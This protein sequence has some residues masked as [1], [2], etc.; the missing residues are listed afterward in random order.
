MRVWNRQQDTG[1]WMLKRVL[2]GR[3]E[4]AGFG[5]V[6]RV[7]ER[8]RERPF[9]CA[10]DDN[11][12][13]RAGVRARCGFSHAATVSKGAGGSRLTEK[14]DKPEDRRY[15]NQRK[16]WGRDCAWGCDLPGA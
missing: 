15:E 1:E 16:G 12:F 3:D 2:T 8:S 7:S 4:I 9:D 13:E 10:V 14:A 11:T 6:A 5:G